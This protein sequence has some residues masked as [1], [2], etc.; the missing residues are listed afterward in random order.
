MEIRFVEM[1]GESSKFVDPPPDVVVSEIQRIDRLP[2]DPHGDKG[3]MTIS[4][5]NCVIHIYFGRGNPR[6]EAYSL[7]RSY[8]LF[9]HIRVDRIP[10]VANLVTRSEDLFWYLKHWTSNWHVTE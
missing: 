10:E 3:F 6:Y 9:G 4:G 1:M 2:D 7:A 5:E 8:G